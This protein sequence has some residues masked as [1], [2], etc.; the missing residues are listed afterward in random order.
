MSMKPGVTQAPCASTR[1]RAASSIEPMATMR[2]P[3][4]PTSALNGALP[5][6]STTLPPSMSQS[7]ILLSP[8]H[9]ES[10]T[11]H[12]VPDAPQARDDDHAEVGIELHGDDAERE[13][14]ILHAALDH[15]GAPVALDDAERQRAQVAEQ[16]PARVVQDHDHKLRQDLRRQQRALADEPGGDE[17]EQRDQAERAE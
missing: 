13:P 3:W 4:M 14:G 15:D 10:Q 7:S 8:Q 9:R 17:R 5:V 1:S 16:Q 2:P 11:R 12:D 6:P